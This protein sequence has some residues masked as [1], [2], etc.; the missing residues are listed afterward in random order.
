MG[1][2]FSASS[3]GLAGISDPAVFSP[4]L[5]PLLGCNFSLL[6]RH[7]VEQRPMKLANVGGKYGDPDWSFF[8][9]V[10]LKDNSRI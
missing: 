7:V 5:I 3:N 8:H 1:S 10:I 9:S 6:W 2:I 4:S